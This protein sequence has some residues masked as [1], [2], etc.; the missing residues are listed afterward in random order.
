VAVSPFPAR[1]S[2]TLLSPVARATLGSVLP[3]GELIHVAVPLCTTEAPLIERHRFGRDAAPVGPARPTTGHS[4]IIAV[5]ATIAARDLN[6]PRMAPPLRA[7]SLNVFTICI[8]ARIPE[9]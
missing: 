6:D 7:G 8:G 3:D 9:P 5:T 1:A 4:T 2:A